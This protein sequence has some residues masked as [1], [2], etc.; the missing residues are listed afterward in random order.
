VETIFPLSRVLNKQYLIKDGLQELDYMG[1]AQ[2][3][4]KEI[5]DDINFSYP[6]GETIVEANARFELELK[7]ILNTT[8]GKKIIVST[9]G[10]VLSEFMIN[11][12]DFDKD[13]FFELTYPDV[14]EIEYDLN[15]NKFKYIKRN[16][17][18]KYERD[19]R[20]K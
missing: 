2:K 10:T 7:N 8:E 12:F 4:H 16:N 19:Y 5:L 14:H 3:F 11:H 9:H 17:I 1:D 18:I 20:V 15:L 6:Q 13:Y